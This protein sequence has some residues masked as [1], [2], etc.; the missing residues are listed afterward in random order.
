MD[1]LDR[2]INVS[3]EDSLRWKEKFAGAKQECLSTSIET[4]KKEIEF[5]DNILPIIQQEDVTYDELVMPLHNLIS[6]VPEA[7]HRF[8][9]PIQQLFVNL[10]SNIK[11]E[12]DVAYIINRINNIKEESVN[13]KVQVTDLSEYWCAYRCILYR[14]GI[15]D[16]SKQRKIQDNIKKELLQVAL[17]TAVKRTEGIK[18]A[19]KLQQTEE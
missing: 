16:N 2:Q 5:I 14:Y 7:Q 6:M 11:S 1:T 17:N 12:K 10:P 3:E 15:W 8:L 19:E 13:S 4:M 18:T 9:E